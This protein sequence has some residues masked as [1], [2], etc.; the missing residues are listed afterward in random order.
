[1]IQK[2]TVRINVNGTNYERQI[3]PR[4]LLSDFIRHELLLTGTHVG[5]EHGVCGACTVL[6]EGDPI[7]S[8]LTFAV[9]VDGKDIRTVESLASTDDVDA[10]KDAMGNVEEGRPATDTLSV[11][12]AA[13]WEHQGLQCGFCT[14]GILMTMEALLKENPDPTREQVRDAL[15]GHICR[16]TG[17]HDIIDSV[18]S[19]AKIKRSLANEGL[20]TRD[21][22]RRSYLAE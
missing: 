8:C 22:L 18:M 3:E 2:A 17:Y 4:I 15:S 20:S 9:Q 7:R 14:P 13:F 5:C 10:R 19:A 12:Q 21:L 1:M 6:L 11:L 16:C